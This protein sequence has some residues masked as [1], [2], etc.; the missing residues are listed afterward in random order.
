MLMLD[1]LAHRWGVQ[2]G[3]HDIAGRWHDVDREALRD[4]LVELG[5]PITSSDNKTEITEALSAHD[6]LLF[7]QTVEPILVTNFNEPLGFVLRLNNAAASGQSVLVEIVC[8]DGTT[9]SDQVALDTLP[10]FESSEIDGKATSARYV[11]TS[12]RSLPI[13]YHDA[14]I[15][16]VGRSYHAMV[17]APP[18]QLPQFQSQRQ[19]GIFA[20][21]YALPPSG[22]AGLENL[23][24][25]NFGDLGHLGEGF[26]PYGANIVSTLPLLA[27]FSSRPLEP[28]PYSPVSR[29]WWSELYLQPN[30]LP[31]LS[32]APQAQ[33][34]LSS[35]RV[36][37]VASSAADSPLVDYAAVANLVGEV[38][39]QLVS[40]ALTPGSG[41]LAAL[42]EFRRTFPE[43][44]EYAWFRAAVDQ[45]GVDALRHSAK[46]LRVDRAAV[47]R[48]EYFQFAA[49]TQLAKLSATMQSRGQTL[50]LD[51]PLGTNPD[52]Y[53]L[54]HDPTSYAG[55]ATGAPP[56]AL[57]S[58]GQ[59]W[60]FPPP[61]PI[62]ARS[63]GYREFI[64]ALRHHFRYAGLLRIDHLMSLERLWW[65]PTGFDAKTGVYVRYPTH[66]L[67]A[68]VAIEAWRSGTVVVGE[69]LGT[70]S[71]DINEVMK[72]WGMLGMYELQFEP[73]YAREHGLLPPPP[74]NSVAGLNTHDMPTFAGW[75]QGA[76]LETMAEL[77]ITPE[78]DL[79]RQHATRSAEREAL[80]NVLA[81]ELNRPV[82]AEV[83][84]ALAAS[85]E[86]LGASPAAV[87]SLNVEDLWYETK[88]QNVPG[89]H[90]ELP[91]WQRKFSRDPHE[92][93]QEASTQE[94]LARLNER[95]AQAALE[96]FCD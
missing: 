76:D 50:A 35:S 95:R 53:D 6:R 82:E 94:T 37:Q 84:A 36:Q 32:D 8:E 80:A 9:H 83:E 58:G 89:T 1:E 93:L 5:A 78:S 90:L 86:W 72:R 92:A 88:P 85:L 62:R 11:T 29:R 26:R 3:Y 12:I 17:L 28:S 45:H 20:P 14:H 25:A 34:L 52:G 66:E 21:L 4:V 59:N 18:A 57:F 15:E 43:V 46:R 63:K 70:V 44:G 71:D 16:V 31:G 60:G 30:Q 65:I 47:L 64:L 75:W 67:M 54:W 24:M 49:N 42:N 74:A 33:Q 39:D 68:I 87:V 69:N 23:G 2:S 41:T 48:H 79:S 10:P 7:D 77:G 51:L 22:E 19:W 73:A 96:G 56:D 55:V 40:E 81:S 27:T 38:V 13:G 91:N 61:H